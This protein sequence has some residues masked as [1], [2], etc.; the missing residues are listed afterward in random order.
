MTQLA[1]SALATRGLAAAAVLSVLAFAGCGSV[2]G[3]TDGPAQKPAGQ[4]AP[5]GSSST[6]PD[7]NSPSSPPTADPVAFKPSVDDGSQGVKVDS[8]ISVGSSNGTLSSVA[9]SSKQT[10]KGKTKTVRVDGALNKAKTSWT[11]AGALDPGA[12]YT[13]TMSAGP[14]RRARP[15]PPSRASRPRP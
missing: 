15:P 4:T 14:I 11:A 6:T 8:I 1:K 10:T 12:K 7:S 2:P 9:V 3:Q 5:T 13:I